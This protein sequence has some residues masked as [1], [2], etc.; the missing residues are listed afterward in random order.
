MNLIK[1]Y[2]NELI[3]GAAIF[4]FLAALLFK[5]ERK[6]EVL[7]SQKQ[8]QKEL[9]QLRDLEAMKNVWGDKK[10]SK[11]VQRLQAIVPKNKVKWHKEAKKLTASFSNLSGR[12]LNSAVNRILNLPVEIEQLDIDKSGGSYRLECKCKW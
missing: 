12:E 3:L 2:R 10:I 9:A 1:H 8:T 11:K 5:Y 6:T 4:L 7:S